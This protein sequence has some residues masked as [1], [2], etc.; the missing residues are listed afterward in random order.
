[1][2]I[3]AASVRLGL[4]GAVVGGSITYWTVTE[5]RQANLI[6]KAYDSYLPE[7]VRALTIAQKENFEKEEILRFGAA[8]A[9]LTIYGS[10]E[11]QCRAMN[12]ERCLMSNVGKAKAKYGE[13]AQTIR[14][15]ALGEVFV[16]KL[17]DCVLPPKDPTQ[18]ECPIQ[19]Q[20]LS[21]EQ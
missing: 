19:R 8:G 3:Y 5:N 2:S 12:F 1:M 10:K 16:R 15:E 11:V 21:A 13:L 20:A 4:V 18:G 6:L 9:V 7:A 17:N 14:E